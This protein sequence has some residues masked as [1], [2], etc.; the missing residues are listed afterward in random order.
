M[1]LMGLPVNVGWLTL[2]AGT[3]KCP[4][5]GSATPVKAWVPSVNF[6]VPPVVSESSAVGWLLT[7]P[8]GVPAETELVQTWLPANAGRDTLPA[9]TRTLA[10][11]SCSTSWNIESPGSWPTNMRPCANL[12]QTPK[13]RS[14]WGLT[15]TTDVNT[16]P[17]GQTDRRVASANRVNLSTKSC[18]LK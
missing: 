2:P 13:P 14:S 1:T 10:P 5:P 9:G 18:P 7:V 15:S 6:A 4:C 8:A 17:T 3:T 12:C 11:A 16:L